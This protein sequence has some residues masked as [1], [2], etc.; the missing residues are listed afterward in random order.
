MRFIDRWFLFVRIQYFFSPFVAPQVYL[1]CTFLL[2]FIFLHLQFDRLSKLACFKHRLTTNLFLYLLWLLSSIF[3][4]L[5]HCRHPF[6][7]L[8]LY[9][10]LKTSNYIPFDLFDCSSLSFLA[11]HE[12][13]RLL[14]NS[15]RW[16]DMIAKSYFLSIKFPSEHFMFLVLKMGW[17]VEDASRFDGHSIIARRFNCFYWFGKF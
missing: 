5:F 6:I 2:S 10:T 7:L 4:N 3:G 16:D 12:F 17:G 14:V 11:C 15:R 9:L 8:I 13:N 1:C